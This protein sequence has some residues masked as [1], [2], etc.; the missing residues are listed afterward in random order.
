MSGIAAALLLAAT[1]KKI[2]RSW[3]RRM[4][5]PVRSVPDS[6][7]EYRETRQLLQLF[8]PPPFSE[9]VY[10]GIRQRVLREIGR[11]SSAPTL[12]N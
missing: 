5:N 1:S 3:S 2:A 8:A 6:A 11:E 7:D 9:A 12:P 4:C 10:A